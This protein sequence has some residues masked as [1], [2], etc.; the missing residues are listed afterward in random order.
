MISS[1]TG[2]ALLGLPDVVYKIYEGKNN[3][4]TKSGRK[5][6]T[7][8]GT[9]DGKQENAKTGLKRQRNPRNSRIDSQM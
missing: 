8:T 5:L 9:E 1:K 7:K 3:F 6:N 2:N 4:R